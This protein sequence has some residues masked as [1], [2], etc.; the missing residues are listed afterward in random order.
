MQTLARRIAIVI[1]LALSGAVVACTQTK[2]GESPVPYVDDAVVI[3]RVKAAIARDPSLARMQIE[4]Q[5]TRDTV[6]LSGYVDTPEMLV[7]A[8]EIARQASGVAAVQNDLMVK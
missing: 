8:G 6:Q 7:R 1:A 4:V 2:L 5:S 3:A